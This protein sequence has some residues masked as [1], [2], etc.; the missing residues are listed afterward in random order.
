MQPATATHTASSVSDSQVEARKWAQSYLNTRLN[1]KQAD[2]S[3]NMQTFTVPVI[4]ISRTFSGG[5]L[6]ESEVLE[7]KK[8]VAAKIREACTGS[9]Y[10]I[11]SLL[12]IRPYSIEYQPPRGQLTSHV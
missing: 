10:V 2:V 4:D 11:H 9:G 1:A 5:E 6:G 7:E 12:G 8:I 3:S